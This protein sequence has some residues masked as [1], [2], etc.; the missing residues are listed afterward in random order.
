MVLYYELRAKMGHGM[1]VHPESMEILEKLQY[2]LD[3]NLPVRREHL[4]ALAPEIFVY[5]IGELKRLQ[6]E[7]FQPKTIQLTEQDN[8]W[9]FF[10]IQKGR[11]GVFEEL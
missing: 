4:Y 1:T 2:A 6:G 8:V 9:Q 11:W 5:E 10:F 3:H 7:R